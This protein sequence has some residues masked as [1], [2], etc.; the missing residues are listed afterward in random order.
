MTQS[1]Q[2]G[3]VAGEVLN[4][5]NDLGNVGADMSPEQR[6]RSEETVVAAVIVGQVAQLAT[7]TAASAGMSA[8]A[9]STRRIR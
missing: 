8:A 4:A 9:A 5:F 6:E 7:A 1:C 2:I 3:A